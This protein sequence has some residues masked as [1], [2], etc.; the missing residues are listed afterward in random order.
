MFIHD[1][2]YS[3]Y[4][5]NLRWFSNYSNNSGNAMY[6]SWSTEQ[7]RFDQSN[8]ALYTAQHEDSSR[9]ASSRLHTSACSSFF[10]LAISPSPI[11]SFLSHLQFSHV[12]HD[13]YYH[14]TKSA[15]TKFRFS[16]VNKLAWSWNHIPYFIRTLLSLLIHYFIFSFFLLYIF[17]FFIVKYLIYSLYTYKFEHKINCIIIQYKINYIMLQLL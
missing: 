7:T 17:Y 14:V 3:R 1:S 6:Q 4:A 16:G 8:G 9:M 5:G 13:K 2:C 11:R 10:S 15:F 12:R